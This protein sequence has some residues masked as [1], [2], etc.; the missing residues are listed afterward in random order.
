MCCFKGQ[1]NC[2]LPPEAERKKRK[3]G[4]EEGSKGQ[5][6]VLAE[7]KQKDEK[8]KSAGKQRL[9]APAEAP[10]LSKA[11]SLSRFRDGFG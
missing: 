6:L 2:D 3:A 11:T 4:E 8:T 5:G 7:Q 1:G 10:C 9:K